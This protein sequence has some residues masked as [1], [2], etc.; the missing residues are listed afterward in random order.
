MAEHTKGLWHAGAI[1]GVY[2][3]TGD[4]VANAI[5]NAKPNEEALANARLIAAAP[6]LLAACKAMVRDA[7]GTTVAERPATKQARDVIAEAEGAENE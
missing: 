6:K 4:L 7:E 1:G 3:Q 2:D 5:R